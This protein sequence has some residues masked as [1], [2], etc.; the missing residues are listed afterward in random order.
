[1]KNASSRDRLDPIDLD[2]PILMK[3]EALCSQSLYTDSQSVRRAAVTASF[4]FG[5]SSKTR[6][7]RS[8]NA[9]QEIKKLEQERLSAYLHL[10]LSSL[11]RIMSDDYRS[12]YADGQIVT[13]SQEMQ[14]IKSAPVGMLSSLAAKIDELSVRLFGTTALL[15]G[16]LTI[17]GKIVWSEKDIDIN[18]ACRYTAVYVKTGTLAGRCLTIY[19]DR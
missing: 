16:R 14:G 6:H 12:I 8:A 5:Q 17:K 2:T 3:E 11:E 10:D 15:S 1:M 4:A 18:A 9:E 19:E 7:A 13:K